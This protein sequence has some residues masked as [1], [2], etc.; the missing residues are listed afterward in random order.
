MAL[1]RRMGP[2]NSATRAVLMD[3]VES[4]MR[5]DGYAAL[6]ARSVARRA[7]LKYQLVFY[8][9]ETMDDLLLAT[10]RRRSQ[11]VLEN[12]EKALSSE[13]P[14]HAFWQA[15]RDPSDAALS[16]E[17]MALSNHNAA[18]RAET[19]DLGE[20]IHRIELAKL[21]ERLKQS[22]PAPEILTPFAITM[23]ISCIASVLGFESAL[24]I[25]GGHRDTQA[26]VE[27]CLGQ[28]EP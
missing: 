16:F 22:T 2:E 8:Y 9:F 26:L 10:Y 5:E 1:K 17:Y 4:V 28:L 11:R 21:S 24:G 27:W 3:A 15:A 13:R 6:S 20:R 14:L 18:I 25:S 19:A 23:A 7:N 12:I